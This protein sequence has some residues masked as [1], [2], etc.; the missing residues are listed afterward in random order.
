MAAVDKTADVMVAAVELT[1]N[2]VLLQD[3]LPVELRLPMCLH[4]RLMDQLLI[5]GLNTTPP[6]P[7]QQQ[8]LQ[9]THLK[10]FWQKAQSVIL[11]AILEPLMVQL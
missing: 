5:L 8:P 3:L 7:R 10:V 2:Q 6:I 1:Q 4:V 11:E 9:Q